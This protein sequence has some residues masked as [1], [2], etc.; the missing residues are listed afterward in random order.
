MKD[1]LSDHREVVVTVTSGYAMWCRQSS[2]ITVDNSAQKLN[3]WKSLKSSFWRKNNVV[4]R[5]DNTHRTYIGN[6]NTLLSNFWNTAFYCFQGYHIGFTYGIFSWRWMDELYLLKA[7]PLAVDNNLFIC[8][9]M[10]HGIIKYIRYPPNNG[11]GCHF[12]RFEFWRGA[13]QFLPQ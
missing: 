7:E 6:L 11:S 4:K 1:R 9:L 13:S 12:S 3:V 5:N 2:W 10:C 8:L